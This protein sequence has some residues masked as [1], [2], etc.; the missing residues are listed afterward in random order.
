[1]IATITFEPEGIFISSIILSLVVR[2]SGLAVWGP[3]K[4]GHCDEIGKTLEGQRAHRMTGATN[5]CDRPFH[6]NLGG[7]ARSRVYRRRFLQVN[8][9]Y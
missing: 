6:R 1:M 3:V 2:M 7:G 9:E 4:L 5:V 8:T